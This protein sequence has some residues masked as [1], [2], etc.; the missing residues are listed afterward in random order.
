MRSAGRRDHSVVDALAIAVC[1]GALVGCPSFPDSVTAISNPDAT[2]DSGAHDQCALDFANGDSC[3]RCLETEC[4]EVGAACAAHPVCRDTLACMGECR[5]EDAAEGCLSQCG[6]QMGPVDDE[7]VAAMMACMG[8]RCL[9]VCGTCG[10][11]AGGLDDRCLA[12]V[13][14]APDACDGL[15]EC[16][17]DIDCASVLLCA[18][19]CRNP[20][21]LISCGRRDAAASGQIAAFTA[22]MASTC[23]PACGFGRTWRCVD[24]FSWPGADTDAPIR[25]KLTV[26]SGTSASPLAAARVRVCSA[27]DPKCEMPVVE[28]TTDASGVVVVELAV[29][30]RG[31]GGTFLVGDSADEIWMPIILDPGRRLT[32]NT[33]L[34]AVVAERAHLAILASALGS[35]IDPARAHLALFVFDCGLQPGAGVQFAVEPNLD[36]SRPIYIHADITD[37]RSTETDAVG[38]AVMVNIDL[39]GRDP[40]V[41]IVSGTVEGRQAPVAERQTILRA[42]HVTEVVLLPKG[43][44]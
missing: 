7:A 13:E 37:P 20:A 18:S 12:C 40:S 23:G 25:V 30:P 35:S 24:D 34:T 15:R 43:L 3:G 10:P 16:S 26:I 9:P 8:Q 4:C 14:E 6:S 39:D 22:P 41:V 38:Q 31:F 17:A 32:E 1:I 28:G 21:C 5:A 2:V 33:G 29:G 19:T 36:D 11:Q 42:G 44:N 27:V